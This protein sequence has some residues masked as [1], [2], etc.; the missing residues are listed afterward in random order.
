MKL[1][2]MSL[3]TLLDMTL[4]PNI[5][6]VA[7][8]LV[9]KFRWNIQATGTSA[10]NLL[11]LSTQIQ[12]RYAYMSDGPNRTYDINGQQLIFRHT[13][14]KD[15]GFKLTHSALL[16]QGLKALGPEHISDET[17]RKLQK[18]IP[19]DLKPKI[20]KDTRSAISWVRDAILKVCRE[21]T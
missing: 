8:T 18:A 16:V 17:I 13:A 9:R 19:E 4:N 2:R 14:F 3:F 11:G 20:R 10:L 1:G 7:T 12:G 6:Q 5:D 15:S 21:N